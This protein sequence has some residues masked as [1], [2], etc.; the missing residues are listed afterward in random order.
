M[1]MTTIEQQS[2]NNNNATKSM[3]GLSARNKM[4]IGL[5]NAVQA[6]N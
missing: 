3:Y 2:A 6:A 4:K 5:L 1:T